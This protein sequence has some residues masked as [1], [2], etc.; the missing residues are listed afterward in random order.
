MKYGVGI[1]VSKG[2]STIAIL[3]TDGEIIKEP[4]EINH[5]NLEFNNLDI[6]LSN[7]SKDSLKIIMKILVHITY[8][9]LTS[10]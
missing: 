1:D 5:N 3:S 7:Y 2:K 8:Q 6:L 10:F 4:F 9:F